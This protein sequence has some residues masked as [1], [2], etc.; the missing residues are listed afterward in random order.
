MIYW[1]LAPA[2]LAATFLVLIPGL[3][4]A[5]SMGA[6]G[7][8]LAGMAGPTSITL[9]AVTAVLSG[10]SSLPWNIFSVLLL[11]V[12]AAVIAA[13]VRQLY[14]RQCKP[15][16]TVKGFPR[17]FIEPASISSIAAVILPF[18]LIMWRMGGIVGQ[19]GNISQT[20]DNI[21]HLNAVRYIEET[22]RASSLLV[23]GFTSTSGQAG[24]YP[25][26]WHDFVSLV[27][28]MTGA[29]IPESV[30]ASNMIIA[31]IVWPLSCI[32]LTVTL[33]GPRRVTLL[34]SGVLMTG[35][36][37]FPYLMVDFGV[38]YPNFL[39]IAILPAAIALSVGLLNLSSDVNQRLTRGVG[40]FVLLL[41][42][43]ALAHPSTLLALLPWT[44]PAV[45]TATY[46]RVRG[47]FIGRR[48]WTTGWAEAAALLAYVV[49]VAVLWKRLR[50]TE[51]MSTWE[52]IQ[53]LSQA[54]GQALASAPVSGPVPWAIFFLTLVGIYAL[55]S[56]SALRWYLGVFGV[57]CMA[58][59]V[60]S[61]A[62][63]GDLRTF[64]GGVW[65]NDPYR[66]AALLPVAAL[67]VAVFGA[68]WL[69]DRLSMQAG[70]VSGLASNQTTGSKHSKILISA[71]GVCAVA[72]AIGAVQRGAVN[73]VVFRA[74]Q[75]YQYREDAA[76]LSADEKALLTRIPEN[77]PPEA[78][79]VAS[80]WTGASLVY[81]L[82]DRRSLT[83]HV[84]G[85]YDDATEVVLQHL[86]EMRTDPRVCPAVRSLDS[87]YV[88]DFGTAEVHGQS[89][90]FPG[91]SELVEGP[92]FVLVDSE[93]AAKLY[94]VTGCDS[95]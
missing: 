1:Q 46:R 62:S 76:L 88:L 26:A 52:P 83:A 2:L 61:G 6:R 72:V 94:R 18:V 67:P 73:E 81:A 10:F 7:W 17:R 37:S 31:S 68:I 60:V 78:A 27:S 48:T 36:A 50:P 57:S 11:A 24:F 21:F 29:G 3:V 43:L 91:T 13:T 9:I 22:G 20:F 82:A 58:F 85:T 19:P 70:F 39:S 65:Y 23:A 30:N 51:S 32:L 8:L 14:L 15:E 41:P 35:F 79:L 90:P 95:L 42:G 86:D 84:F 38:L 12:V 5:R 34:A 47:Q 49:V 71:V 25:A 53:S 54:I 44:L 45:V 59:V 28:Q 74:A 63:F 92:D 4:I 64:V 55:L 40:L 33:F 80:P 16:V 69:W 93:G 77:V 87:Y 89:H 66:P 56:N 75:N